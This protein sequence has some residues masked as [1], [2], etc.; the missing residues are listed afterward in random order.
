[1]QGRPGASKMIDVS[2]SRYYA[3]DLTRKAQD[4]TDDFQMCMR[5]KPCSNT[6][7]RPPIE[8]TYGPCDEPEDVIEID[9]IC[10]LPAS[11]RY[12]HILTVF[13]NFS[14]NFFA[15]PLSQPSTNAVGHAFLQTFAQHGYVPKHILTYKRSAFTSK[16][17]TALMSESGIKSNHTTLKYAQ[18]FCS[19]WA[20]PSKAPSNLKN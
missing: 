19:S 9:S 20:N 4:Y 14:R 18:T 7:L 12:T 10:E 8:Q 17:L 15:I 6:K 1:M 2:R 16:V 11:N 13:D 3:P 5:A